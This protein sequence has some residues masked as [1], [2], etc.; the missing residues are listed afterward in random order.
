MHK[1]DENIVHRFEQFKRDK[2]MELNDKLS[3]VRKTITDSNSVELNA[4]NEKINSLSENDSLRNELISQKDKLIEK[5]QQ[6]ISDIE[7]TAREKLQKVFSELNIE[8]KAESS[9]EELIDINNEKPFIV[10]GSHNIDLSQIH[11]SEELIDVLTQTNSLEANEQ[12]DKENLAYFIEFANKNPSNI[13]VMYFD[14]RVSR[15]NQSEIIVNSTFNDNG[16]GITISGINHKKILPD[17]WYNYRAAFDYRITMRNSSNMN[18]HDAISYINTLVEEANKRGLNLR[19]KNYW[20]QDAFILYLQKGDL[21]ETVKMLEDLKDS[22]KYGTEVSRATQSFGAPAPFG[23]T[24]SDTPY[25][26][27]TMSHYEDKHNNILS[28]TYGKAGDTFNGYIGSVFKNTYD[29]MLEKYNGDTSKITVDEFYD[30]MYEEH[31]KIMNIQRDENIP[32]WMNERNYREYLESKTESSSI[33]T[34]NVSQE[35]KTDSGV[36]P[37]NDMH[38]ASN[39]SDVS[40]KISMRTDSKKAKAS[41]EKMNRT[42]IDSS[43]IDNNVN[44]TSQVINNVSTTLE[45]NDNIEVIKVDETNK[46]SKI[47]MTRPKF[48]MNKSYGGYEYVVKPKTD[49]LTAINEIKSGNFGNVLIEIPNTL[50]LTQ[51]VV[52]NIPSNVEVRITGGY[53][54]EFLNA[55]GLKSPLVTGVSSLQHTTYTA[56]E[57]RSIVSELNKFDSLVDPSWS[58]S[59]KAQFVYEY[60]RDNIEYHGASEIVGGNQTRAKYYDGLM[61]LVQ[62]QSTCQGFAYTYNALLERLNVKSYVVSGSLN[63]VGQHVFNVVEIDGKLVVVDST[64][65]LLKSNEHIGIGFNPNSIFEYE[66]RSYDNLQNQLVKDTL[67]D[68]LTP[69]NLETALK[70]GEYRGIGVETALSELSKIDGVNLDSKLQD[71]IKITETLSE[72]EVIFN[73]EGVYYQNAEP[74]ILTKDF[75][76]TLT[77]EQKEF[78]TQISTEEGLIEYLQNNPLTKLELLERGELTHTDNKY[79]NKLIELISENKGVNKQI[80]N[81][82][83]VVRNNSNPIF[84]ESTYKGDTH[85]LSANEVLDFM[86]T[87]EVSTKY[88]YSDYVKATNTLMNDLASQKS[89]IQISD[90]SFNIVNKYN[91]LMSGNQVIIN[92]DEVMANPDITPITLPHTINGIDSNIVYRYLNNPELLNNLI[93]GNVSDA[94]VPQLAS[95]LK[96]MTMMSD[97]LGLEMDYLTKMNIELLYMRNVEDSYVQAVESRLPNIYFEFKET[98][99]NCNGSYQ[100]AISE[101]EKMGHDIDEVVISLLSNASSNAHYYENSKA[102]Y[103]YSYDYLISKGYT[104][105]DATIRVASIYKKLLDA[106]GY[107]T[108]I[109]KDGIKI[110]VQKGI[111]WPNQPYTLHYIQKELESIK[112]MYKTNIPV[113]VYVYDTFNPYDKYWEIQYNMK[114]FHSAATGGY[115][116]I[117][118]YRNEFVDSTVL[119][120][121][122]GHLLDTQIMNDNNSVGKISESQEYLDAISKDNGA[123]TA[124]A[125]TNSVEDFAESVAHMRQNPIEFK[126]KFPNRYEVLSKYMSIETSVDVTSTNTN[127]VTETTVQNSN[128]DSQINTAFENMIYKFGVQE[129]FEKLCE[130]VRTGNIDVFTEMDDVRKVISSVDKDSIV[131][132][133]NENFGEE[134]VKERFEYIDEG[135]DTGDAVSPMASVQAVP[136]NVDNVVSNTFDIVI[137]GKV[138]SSLK[139]EELVS[140]GTKLSTCYELMEESQYDEFN[141]AIVNYIDYIRENNISVDIDSNVMKFY[142]SYKYAKENNVFIVNEDRILEKGADMIAIPQEIYNKY[143]N[144]YTYQTVIYTIIDGIES[145]DNFENYIKTLY[146]RNEK[147]INY[148]NY[149]INYIDSS[150]M[151]NENYNI[152]YKTIS[153]LSEHTMSDSTLCLANVHDM[154][155]KNAEPIYLPNYINGEFRN[156]HQAIKTNILIDTILGKNQFPSSYNANITENCRVLYNYLQ[157]NNITLNENIMEKLEFVNSLNEDQII[158]NVSEYFDGKSPIVTTEFIKI[159]DAQISSLDIME[160]LKMDSDAYIKLLR[161]GICEF[162][163]IKSDNLILSIQRLLSQNQSLSELYNDNY[164]KLKDLYENSYVLNNT[165]SIVPKMFNGYYTSLID[166][167]LNKPN[168]INSYNVSEKQ[169]LINVINDFIEYLKSNNVE[170][171]YHRYEKVLE[172][173]NRNVPNIDSSIAIKSEFALELEANEENGGAFGSDQG[174]LRSLLKKTKMNTVIEKLF[175]NKIEEGKL[176]EV[177]SKMDISDEEL[178]KQLLKSNRSLFF[179]KNATEI[180]MIDDYAIQ[181]MK[182]YPGMNKKQAIQFL[183]LME[184][185]EGGGSGICNYASMVNLVFNKYMNNPNLFEEKLGYPMYVTIDGKRQLN[186]ATLLVDLYSI[187]NEN[188]LITKENGIYKISVSNAEYLNLTNNDDGTIVMEYFQKFLDKKGI[189]RNVSKTFSYNSYTDLMYYEESITNIHDALARGE[190]IHLSSGGFN[191]YKSNGNIRAEN[192]GGHIMSVVGITSDGNLIVDSWGEKLI[193]NLKEEMSE[194]GEKYKYNDGDIYSKYIYI[195]SYDISLDSASNLSTSLDINTEGNIHNGANIEIFDVPSPKSNIASS[196]IT[197]EDLKF[198]DDAIDTKDVSAP[199][200]SIQDM[201][202]DKLSFSKMDYG[203]QKMLNLQEYFDV[204]SPVIISE[205]TE[206]QGAKISSL[207]IIEIL[208][209]DSDEYIKLLRDGKCKFENITRDNLI[210]AVEKLLSQNQI[211]EEQYNENYNKLKNLLNDSYVLKDTLTIV[212]KM[213]N[214]CDTPLIHKILDN[215]HCINQYSVSERHNLAIAANEYIEY[216]KRIEINIEDIYIEYENVLE[217]LNREIPNVDS[218][219]AIETD[220]CKKFDR[221]GNIFGAKQDAVREMLEKSRIY[222]SIISYSGKSDKLL[223]GEMTFMQIL[224]EMNISE[225][226][227][228]KILLRADTNLMKEEID[229]KLADLID[230]VINNYP[231]MSKKEALHFLYLMETVEGSVNGE[232]N[233]ICNYAATV[234]LI[235]DMFKGKPELFEKH[236]GYPMFIDEGK[237]QL[238]TTRLL[239]D[240]Y[241]IINDGELVKTENGKYKIDLNNE[242]YKNLTTDYGTIAREPFQKFLDKKGIKFNIEEK[243]KYD[244]YNEFEFKHY[245]EVITNIHDCL[246][247]G[248]HVHLSSGGFNLYYPN[249]GDAYKNGESH[250]MSVVGITS[251]GNLIV[252]S[253]G[254]KLIFNLREEMS[255]IGGQDRRGNSRYVQ[256][257]SYNISLD[258]S[259]NISTNSN[260]DGNINNG[261]TTQTFGETINSPKSSVTSTI[262]ADLDI[263][264]DVNNEGNIHNSSYTEVFDVPSDSIKSNVT[265]SV[266]TDEDLEFIDVSRDTVGVK[267]PRTSV[268]DMQSN[269]DIVV[270]NTVNIDG[271]EIT[272]ETLKELQT[273]SNLETALKTG[274]Y[275]G[276]RVEK[277]LVELSKLDGVTLDSKLQELVKISEIL[278]ENEIIFNIEDVYS[279]GVLPNTI[280]IDVYNEFIRNNPNSDISINDLYE[281]INSNSVIYRLISNDTII[282]NVSNESIKESF[283]YLLSIS[284]RYNFENKVIREAQYL[285]NL[286]EDNYTT[287]ELYDAFAIAHTEFNTPDVY[288][289]YYDYLKTMDVESAIKLLGSK[290]Y[291][292]LDITDAFLNFAIR[293]NSQTYSKHF[294]YKAFDYLVENGMN[295]KEAATIIRDKYRTLINR[296]GTRVVTTT[297]NGVKIKIVNNISSNNKL[298][299][300]EKIE[301]MIKQAEKYYSKTGLK[302]IVIFDSFAPHNI[303]SE[304]VQYEDYVKTHNNKRFVAAASATKSSIILWEDFDQLDSI[305]HEYGHTIDKHIQSANKLTTSFSSSSTWLEAIQKDTYIT[306]KRVSEYAY[307]SNGEDFAEFLK[308]FNRKPLDVARKYP[309]RYKAASK[310]LN[311]DIDSNII[312]RYLDSKKFF[313]EG[314]EDLS[315]LLTEDGSMLEFIKQ[316]LFE[317]LKGDNSIAKT[318]ISELDAIYESEIEIIEDY[319]LYSLFMDMREQERIDS[320]EFLKIIKDYLDGKDIS[321]KFKDAR[322]LEI[323]ELL[324]KEEIQEWYEEELNEMTAETEKIGVSDEE[325]EKMMNSLFNDL[326]L[327]SSSDTSII[328]DEESTYNDS[329]IEDAD[330]DMAFPKKS[331]FSKKIET[332]SVSD[333]PR[334]FRNMNT[335][336]IISILEGKTTLKNDEN[337]INN[338]KSII[339][340]VKYL[341]ENNIKLSL[342]ERANTIIENLRNGDFRLNIL[343]FSDVLN[344]DTPIYGPSSISLDGTKISTDDVMVYLENKKNEISSII[345]SDTPN[346]DAR[347]LLNAIDELESKNDIIYDKYRKSIKMLERIERSYVYR[348][349]DSYYLLPKSFNGIDTSNILN[350]DLISLTSFINSLSNADKKS[351]RVALDEFGKYIYKT[352]TK[353]SRQDLSRVNK[354]YD[355]I[356]TKKFSIDTVIKSKIYDTF[357][358]SYQNDGE[359]GSNQGKVREVIEKLGITDVIQSLFSEKVERSKFL[360]TLS[361]FNISQRDF[362]TALNKRTQRGIMNDLFKNGDINLGLYSSLIRQVKMNYPNMSTMEAVR[363]LYLIETKEAG[364]PG[365]CNNPI[366]VNM[367][368]DS[369]IGRETI[370]ERDFGYPMYINAN[371]GKKVLNEARLLVDIFSTL[372]DGVLVHNVNGNYVINTTSEN[373]VRAYDLNGLRLDAIEKFINKKGINLNLSKSYFFNS[374]EELMHYDYLIERIKSELD[375]GNYV[376]FGGKGFDMDVENFEFRKDCDAHGMTIVGIDTTG[377]LILDSWGMKARVDLKKELSRLNTMFKDRSSNMT[378]RIFTISSYNIN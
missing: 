320:N 60:L 30:F 288:Y 178:T 54:L 129:S 279:N 87:G 170:I 159:Q 370:F 5:Q 245:E 165:L 254:M 252:D 302:E 330:V 100:L 168:S 187:I 106:R 172:F 273:P 229:V 206:I 351:Y 130:Y 227:F 80:Y 301:S 123:P 347:D 137:D 321:S 27:V 309:N 203:N 73:R 294:Y 222:R 256:L 212:P 8:E 205:F 232:V 3:E 262:D 300:I 143:Q 174:I 107:D 48:D 207:D 234:N 303:Y 325:F 105:N 83:E 61:N 147:Y 213:F 1:N 180:K 21:L 287:E 121:E 14:D 128:V 92:I 127:L 117:N 6:E 164:M 101:F 175:G 157:S 63:G 40:S 375:K 4:I 26:T 31:K 248:E 317:N 10:P 97:S 2:I 362:I 281:I 183:Y 12:R 231:G 52:D 150:L 238:N 67:I 323:I 122:Y 66:F 274:E 28:S 108:L 265:S 270:L 331:I 86:K 65:E 316:Y 199:D 43:S 352:N 368:F 91:D 364:G 11:S 102:M 58:D 181:V 120:H 57:L 134:I 250:I 173:L 160:I 253:W 341:S 179:A 267:A 354:L 51:E 220:L 348:S 36:S 258:N 18:P 340:F 237:T 76:S 275:A 356:N 310:Y 324:E 25:Y 185:E 98:L 360:Q 378:E 146:L 361:E 345:T 201:Q 286:L 22:S 344:G 104:Q 144:D 346:G 17:G 154:I 19:A 153:K 209:M 221:N 133:L 350:S 202:N 308:Y 376:I 241:S 266:I 89:R 296:R 34:N 269:P 42:S 311:L 74:L 125:K 343:N 191:L 329:L 93:N 223:F 334:V 116:V 322:N 33:A 367:I 328:K 326:E 338:K 230:L 23:A 109:G 126:N 136:I 255:K 177:L 358:M 155:Y 280:N 228:G 151:T 377:E 182:N 224:N 236:M 20:E 184:T 289:E 332:V 77:Q 315:N 114:N 257:V 152:V 225:E 277:A 148:A 194:L 217:F 71:L 41:L 192:I 163:D 124:Y 246:V 215:P 216:L 271:V 44:S 16:S 200:A 349:Y 304:K 235:F 171:E 138:E 35:S 110:H 68:L 249:G 374:N 196:V 103:D 233:G 357:E 353:L 371:N 169:N 239:V 189:D 292:T 85:T 59:K 319:G 297:P 118:I 366:L 282:K 197:D 298:F 333:I 84:I 342:N 312:E 145:L 112:K 176:L 188:V 365:I 283:E 251:D 96:T 211:L 276:V 247:R 372:N 75:V 53:T 158:L 72:N 210:K 290:G 299:T 79:V 363:F 161:D 291:T 81:V 162:N 214:E 355:V 226:D 167:I 47:V 55:R 186:T 307:A 39:V 7:N 305:V 62:R 218:N 284:N 111:Y 335:T 49:L 140:N 243:F 82:E 295:E 244:P 373:Y 219:I 64:R 156:G 278:K 131:K 45:T 24:I 135:I 50:E 70:T 314:I 99:R 336:D 198:S 88:S 166:T 264:T 268:Q 29:K 119:S 9:S 313:I 132:Y 115:G 78:L 306:S 318:V 208:K 204:Q 149:L 359:F 259:S 32:F 339:R 139:L 369:Y 240:L 15:C 190:H 141:S 327:N 195:V 13:D 285:L 37:K 242:N 90:E 193:F 113:D 56:S 142:E 337:F 46:S 95:A 261:T 69:S 272:V 263:N 293:G 94:N 260:S 38:T